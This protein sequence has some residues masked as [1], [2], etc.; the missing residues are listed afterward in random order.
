MLLNALL[1]CLPCMQAL[2]PLVAAVGFEAGA[3]ASA[4]AAEALSRS[5]VVLAMSRGNIAAKVR[6][7]PSGPLSAAWKGYGPE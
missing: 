2:Q 7:A 5:T 6:S 3:G 4:E 1:Q